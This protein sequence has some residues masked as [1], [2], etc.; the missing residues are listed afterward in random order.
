MPISP[1]LNA[2]WFRQLSKE[3]LE[4]SGLPRNSDPRP[5]KDLKD[6]D[7]GLKQSSYWQ[8][9]MEEDTNHGEELTVKG[10][11]DAGM[12]EKGIARR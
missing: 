1:V 11:E 2:T 5:D 9:E 6:H 10:L 12:N 4:A 3:T 7:Q 8:D